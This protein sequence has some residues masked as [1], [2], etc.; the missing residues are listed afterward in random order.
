MASPTKK[1]SRHWELRYK[2]IVDAA[3]DPMIFVD[4]QGR[5]IEWNPAAAS[6]F[7][8]SRRQALGSSLSDLTGMPAE[9]SDGFE[10]EADLK[11]ERWIGASLRGLCPGKGTRG[12]KD[13]RAPCA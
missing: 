2:H 7:G 11:K 1:G 8:Y 10:K 3:R 13:R 6:L 12:G 4:W 5:I 9:A